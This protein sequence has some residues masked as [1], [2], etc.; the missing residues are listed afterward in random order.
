MQCRNEKQKSVS[1]KRT[2]NDPRETL[3]TPEVRLFVVRWLLRFAAELVVVVDCKK[4]HTREIQKLSTSNESVGRVS[5]SF[6]CYDEKG[7]RQPQRGMKNLPTPWTGQIHL[8]LD[9]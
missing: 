8:G 4:T 9:Y 5:L 7:A 1:R 2:N 3:P 6:F